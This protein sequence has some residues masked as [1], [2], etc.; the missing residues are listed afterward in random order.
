MGFL[1]Q[2]KKTTTPLL[3]FYLT[4]TYLISNTMLYDP[5]GPT[6]KQ[7]LPLLVN[8][9]TST[10][11]IPDDA[12]DVAE[13]INVLIG[14]NRTAA[15]IC[16]EVKEVV[17]IPI[18]E[19]FIGRV[20]A[21]IAKL[22]QSRQE[23][24]QTQT[25]PQAQ[26]QE[27]SQFQQPSF[28]SEQPQPESQPQSFPNE[29]PQTFQPESVFNQP[30]NFQNN[31]SVFSNA[32]QNTQ[33]GQSFA[34]EQN[35]ASGQNFQNG[36]NFTNEN[37]F[38]QSAFPSYSGNQDV[39]AD[40]EDKLMHVDFQKLGNELRR[41][42]PQGPKGARGGKSGI[43]KDFQS[44]SRNQKKSFGMK[45]AANLEKALALSSNAQ[46]VNMAPFVPRAPKGRCKDF[47]YCKNRECQFSHPTKKCF[48]YPNC[49]NPPGTCDYLHPSED[50]ELMQELE[51][52]KRQFMDRKKERM[53]VPQVTL[54]KYGI[55][56]SK[57][58]CPFGHPTPANKDAKVIIPKWCRENKNCQNENCEYA[59]S[60]PN[61][62]APVQAPAPAAQYINIPGGSGPKFMNKTGPKFSNF[63]K[64]TPTTLEQCKFGM[65][66]TNQLC[67][68]RHSTSSVACRGG[69]NCTRLDC[70]FNHPIEE[71]CRFGN[72]CKNK[73]CYFRHPDGRERALFEN[74]SDSTSNRSFAVPEDQVMEQAVQQ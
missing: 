13:Y 39:P 11:G 25:Q 58:L 41:A 52:T 54:C 53:M 23:Q 47:P 51:K 50:G 32:T 66:C 73:Y 8:E 63:N 20:F 15:D 18:D 40:S 5:E 6:A 12:Q 17:N 46:T 34:T 42:A 7:L 24:A 74:S 3:F 48:A 16:S 71:D 22:E 9:L 68:K 27:T 61:Y 37:A 67:P 14:N 21:E 65:N 29:Q 69:Y 60:S 45:N 56:C 57:E 36:Q 49:P 64:R 4:V 62:Q 43:S 35:F 10:Y 19:P 1:R 72:E 33:N 59:H 38:P 2:K 44:N 26:T 28:Q 31:N 70:T 30:Q 55:L